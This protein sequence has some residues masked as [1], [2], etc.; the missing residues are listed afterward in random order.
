MQ[1]WIIALNQTFSLGRIDLRRIFLQV[2]QYIHRILVQEDQNG[3]DEKLF[4]TSSL[5]RIGF[6]KKG[7]F[8]E[9]GISDVD[10]YLLKKVCHDILF[11]S[12]LK[13]E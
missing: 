7:D 4:N 10:V 2:D 3:S 13:T 1:L 5:E 11:F 9:S 6:Y 12:P 8:A